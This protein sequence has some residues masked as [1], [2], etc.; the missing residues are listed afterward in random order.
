MMKGQS[1]WI[2]R[3]TST[4]WAYEGY[5]M[6]SKSQSFGFTKLHVL[7]FM[8]NQLDLFHGKQN[9]DTALEC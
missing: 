2:N 9:N 6:Q 8:K 4:N 3:Y 5:M 7:K 1:K